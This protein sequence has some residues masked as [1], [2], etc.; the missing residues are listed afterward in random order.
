VVVS[1]FDLSVM[2]RLAR[3]NKSWGYRGI[4]SELA[5]LGPDQVAA[6]QASAIAA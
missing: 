2:V 6:R 3:E 4:H 1:R 5:E